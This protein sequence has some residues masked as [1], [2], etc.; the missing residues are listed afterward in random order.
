MP[1]EMNHD[2]ESKA[3]ANALKSTG[4]FARIGKAFQYSMQG[5]AHAVRF[6]AAFRQELVMAIPAII[7]VWF[8]PVTMLEKIVLLGTVALMLITELLNSAIEATVDR[9][10]IERHPLSGRAK[11]LGS[12]AVFIAVLLMLVAW[13]LI[14]GPALWKLL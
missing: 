2:D 9:V 4:G 3:A 7:G 6:E 12:A 13:L 1:P 5:L 8:L 14:A 10:S 11:D